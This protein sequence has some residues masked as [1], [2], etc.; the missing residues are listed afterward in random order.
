MVVDRI[1]LT[2]SS[3]GGD[4]VIDTVTL[5]GVKA[6]TGAFDADWL[7]VGT[8]TLEDIRVGDDGDINSADLI[9]NS[10]VTVNTMNDGV[11]EEPVNIR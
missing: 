3:T 9:I 11:V 2:Q 5:D 1:L 8:L 4:V 7:D 10:S 6:F